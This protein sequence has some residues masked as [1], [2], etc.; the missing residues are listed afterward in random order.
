M[1]NKDG[2]IRMG[3]TV[4]F[5]S[6]ILKSLVNILTFVQINLYLLNGKGYLNEI[7]HGENSGD[8][9]MISRGW[10]PYHVRGLVD[11]PLKLATTE[12]YF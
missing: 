1:N 3:Y 11:E 8:F 9:Q 7:A 10:G 6:K 4:E 2:Y 5:I 12:I